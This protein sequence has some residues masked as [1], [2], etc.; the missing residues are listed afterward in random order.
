MVNSNRSRKESV[1]SLGKE[2]EDAVF[3]PLFGKKGRRK[4]KR[5]LEQGIVDKMEGC[6]R[7]WEFTKGQKEFVSRWDHCTI[8]SGV[9]R[10]PFRVI[11]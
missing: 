7:Q 2:Q 4:A 6:F 10:S 8:V 3:K 11:T 9:E 1:F 5:W